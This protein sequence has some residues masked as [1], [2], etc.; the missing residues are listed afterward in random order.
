MPADSNLKRPG[1]FLIIAGYAAGYAVFEIMAVVT[2]D[3]I[4]T[5]NAIIIS[6]AVVTV[7]I[8]AEVFL[9]KNSLKQI[10]T[11]LGLGKPSLSSVISALIITGLLFLC[12]PLI[13]SITGYTFVIPG[14]WLWLAIGVFVLH[15]IAEEVLYRAYLFGNL[16]KGR[17]FAKAA[18]LAVGFF[19]VAHIP[20]IIN[21][22]VFVGGAA[23]VLAVVSSFPFAWL[24]E[25][26]YNT[27]WAPA[28]VHFAVDT[29]IP[30]LALGEPSPAS[31][32]AVI[33]WMAAG[34]VI[35]YLA[36]LIPKKKPS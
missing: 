19:T 24:Y 9:L 1:L 28:I 20:I 14:N 31:Q 36:F 17:S 22:G 4:D 5:V 25:K 32:Q 23:V 7:V 13:S 15:G 27:I 8:L 11:F 29:V 35:P 12:Y 2:G 30:I 18:W 33:L 10:V 3:S 6:A 34:M 16:R 26:G 21:Q